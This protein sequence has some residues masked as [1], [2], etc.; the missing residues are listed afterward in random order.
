MLG[1]EGII[2]MR[3][4]GKQPALV[5]LDTIRDHAPMKAWEDWPDVSPLVPTVWIQPADVPRRLDLRFVIDLTVVITATDA[6]R[7]RQIEQRC[8]ECGAFRVV[9]SLV[10][11][12]AHQVRGETKFHTIRVTDS[13]IPE[14]N[15]E[16]QEAPHG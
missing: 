1:H 8:I 6:E 14:N 15:T 7:L 12:L 5:Y 4:R 2:T 11:Q 16:P 10:A 3:S 13:L 9:A